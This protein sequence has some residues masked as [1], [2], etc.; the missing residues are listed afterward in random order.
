MELGENPKQG[1]YCIKG[2][3]VTRHWIIWEGNSSKEL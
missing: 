2:A 1:R 3:R